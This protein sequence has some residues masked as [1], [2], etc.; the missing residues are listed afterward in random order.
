LFFKSYYIS[1]Y[2]SNHILILIIL[3]IYFFLFI[4]H[5]YFYKNLYITYLRYTQEHI[6]NEKW[7]KVFWKTFVG[8][9]ISWHIN[10]GLGSMV[11]WDFETIPSEFGEIFFAILTIFSH[12][13]EFIKILISVTYV[14]YFFVRHRILNF[15]YIWK[16]CP[17]IHPQ[18]ILSNLFFYNIC[19]LS[20]G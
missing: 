17:R 7:V 5:T 12:A 9:V 13:Y 14:I 11:C 1:I 19:N 18:N 10:L 15:F 3:L 4:L 16:M 20:N 2:F 6:Y 8:C